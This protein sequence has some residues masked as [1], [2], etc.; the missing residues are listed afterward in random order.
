MN[1]EELEQRLHAEI[2]ELVRPPYAAPDTLRRRVGSL[3]MLEPVRYGSGRGV[4]RVFRKPRNLAAAAV[5]A[6]LVGSAMFFRP[7]TTH[8]ANS[9]QLPASFEM[10][11]RVDANSA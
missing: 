1:D 3:D 8:P 11:G 6:L 4:P 9:V 10:F 7:P 5:V 2:Q